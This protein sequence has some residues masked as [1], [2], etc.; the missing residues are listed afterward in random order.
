MSSVVSSS[1]VLLLPRLVAQPW[2]MRP[3]LI[4]W[5]CSLEV[6]RML[7]ILPLPAGEWPDQQCVCW[8]P[9]GP[10]LLQGVSPEG[11]GGPWRLVQ[12]G[13]QEQQ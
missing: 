2:K 6:A 5:S 8:L 12:V 4:C 7:L 3:S 1:T 10:V 9:G 13:D 11:L